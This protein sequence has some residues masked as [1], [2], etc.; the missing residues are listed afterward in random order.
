MLDLIE[1]LRR[2]RQFA[3]NFENEMILCLVDIAVVDA[4]AQAGALN[5]NAAARKLCEPRLR[6][7]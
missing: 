3:E 1:E 5:D 4:S 7:I 2:V 6:L